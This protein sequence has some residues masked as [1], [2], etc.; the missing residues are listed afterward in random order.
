MP[1]HF[2]QH[3]FTDGCAVCRAIEA[4]LPP[5][6]HNEVCRIRMEGILSKTCEGK[7]MVEGGYTRLA[8][9]AQRIA[10]RQN[11]DASGSTVP[12][13][14]T[15]VSGGEA[16]AEEDDTSDKKRPCQGSVA[17]SPPSIDGPVAGAGND[18]QARGTPRC[19][20]LMLQEQNGEIEPRVQRNEETERWR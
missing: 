7:E 10:E 8:S 13:P 9:A 4:R 11:A 6:N 12:G 2:R 14:P 5:S 15:V 18:Q 17:E 19:R 16:Q 1:N 20:N 3:G